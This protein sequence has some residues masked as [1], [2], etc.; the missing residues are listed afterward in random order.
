LSGHSRNIDYKAFVR[1][2]QRAFE[3]IY[4]AH[5][6]QVYRYCL[7]YL[8]IAELAEET[9]ADIFVRLYTSRHR[10]DPDRS[11]APFLLKIARDTIYNQLKRISRQTELKAQWLSAFER[12]VPEASSPED[13]YLT[14]ELREQ[15]DAAIHQLPPRCAE[16][17]RLR[18]RGLKNR[19][20]AKRLFISPNTVR[21][22]LVKAR[23]LLRLRFE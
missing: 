15:I 1:G 18:N 22:Q 14:H 12:A 2:C 5:F 21:A 9:T 19:E 8:K 13:T 10:F 16:I 6:G 20:I 4:Q 17:F 11:I 23:R 7:A 3:G